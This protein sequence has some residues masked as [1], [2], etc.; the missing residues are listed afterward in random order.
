MQTPFRLTFRNVAHSAALASHLELR[1]A[2]LDHLYARI[3]SC[4]VVVEVHGHHQLG[5]D[6]RYHFSIN[7]GLPGHELLVNHAP[8]E[9]GALENA[10]KRADDAFDEVERQ[11]EDR[12][13]RERQHRH[14]QDWANE[15]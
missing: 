2:K 13:T 9:Q 6:E 11:L 12:V 7:V 14:D 1:V 5:H 3:I 15:R 10:F 4:H 8:T